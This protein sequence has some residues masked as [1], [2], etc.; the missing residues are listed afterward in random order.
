MG[1]IPFS[2]QHTALTQLVDPVGFR[3]LVVGVEGEGH[4]FAGHSGPLG[5]FAW[6]RPPAPLASRH[7]KN[8]TSTMA[9]FSPAAVT[10]ALSTVTEVVEVPYGATSTG[11]FWMIA[12]VSN[13]IVTENVSPSANFHFNSGAVAFGPEVASATGQAEQ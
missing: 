12:S 4:L 2:G 1:S 5:Q 13:C 9:A 10:V 8:S 6:P 7:D 3:Q 11:P